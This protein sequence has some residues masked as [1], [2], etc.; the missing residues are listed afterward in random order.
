M[1]KDIG[2]HPDGREAL[3]QG[4]WE[5][6]DPLGRPLFWYFHVFTNLGAPEPIHVG[7]F[8]RLRHVRV[9]NH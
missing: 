8:W 2:E 5:A 3:G 7:S 1:I 6:P 4:M 9:I